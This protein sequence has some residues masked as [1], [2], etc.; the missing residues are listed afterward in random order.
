MTTITT[1]FQQVSM[2]F[3]AATLVLALLGW[4]R[5]P[6]YWGAFFPVWVFAGY[7]MVYYALLLS[8]RF[9]VDE[10][11]LWGSAH[12]FLSAVLVLGGT[13]ALVWALGG[14]HDGR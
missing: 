9:S 8:G 7:G 3:F 1:L 5:H 2:V 14:K 6:R 10:V 12:R 4:R 13:A 11:F